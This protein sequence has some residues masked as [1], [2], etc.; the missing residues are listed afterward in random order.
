VLLELAKDISDVE[1]WAF[2]TEVDEGV[3]ENSGFSTIK[4]PIA[5]IPG[6]SIHI[7]EYKLIPENKVLNK[8]SIS[9][10]ADKS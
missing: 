4:D 7:L 9:H 8:L 6:V 1:Y 5:I 10:D 3:P 2:K